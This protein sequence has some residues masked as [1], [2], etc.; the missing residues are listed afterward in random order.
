MKNFH[1]WN[2]ELQPDQQIPKELEHLGEMVWNACAS[3]CAK[4]CREKA[5]E[6]MDDESLRVYTC[7][8]LAKALND[9]GSS[10]E[11]Y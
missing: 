6:Q 7:L 8:V 9:L 3:E 4:L 11:D 2:N 10:I 5:T 1:K